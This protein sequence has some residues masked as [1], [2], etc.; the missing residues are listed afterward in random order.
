MDEA[1]EV[2][3]RDMARAGEHALEVPDRFLGRGEMVGQEAAA[4]VFGEKTVEAPEAVGLGADV[5]QVHHQ[6]VAGLGALHAHGA[7]QV[8]HRGQ[9]DVAHIVGAVVVLDEA[10]GPVVGLQDEVVAG[11]DPAGHGNVRVPPVVDP[12]V[13]GGRAVQVNLDQRIRHVQKPP[14][15]VGIDSGERAGV[16]H[17]IAG[18]PV[19]PRRAKAAA[20]TRCAGRRR[21]AG[22]K[23]R[24]GMHK[25]H[26][27][28]ACRPA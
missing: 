6:Q 16:R 22:M 28:R 17:A 8:V 19:A 18:L 27:S 25:H 14:G 5:Q 15:W 2:H 26:S 7:G 13:V 1:G 9:V 24:P 20:R 4:I 23:K 3:A 12:F 21:R 11:L 10:A